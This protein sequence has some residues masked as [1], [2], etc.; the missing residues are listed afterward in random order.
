[1]VAPKIKLWIEFIILTLIVGC[2]PTFATPTPIPPLDSNAIN[3]FIAQTADAASAQTVT[4]MPPSTSTATFTPTPRNT[5]TPEP[6]TTP[7]QTFVFPTVTPVNRYQYFRVKHDHQLAMFN[8]KSR[9][10]DGN[11][12]G[13]LR[14]TPEVVP[15]FLLPKEG[16]GTGRTSL[17]G[18]WEVL[19]NSL[20]NNDQNKLRYLKSAGTA[21]FNTAGFP[22]LESLTMGG[23]I[24]RLD[25]IQGEWGQVHTMDPS[26]PPNAAEVNYATSPDLI[27]K[28]VVV[29]WRRSNK[30]TI[31]VKPPKG[32]LYWPLVSRRP[33]WIQ[34]DRLESFP[35]LPLEV[36]ISKE[37]YL[38]TTPG[39]DLDK[40]G[41]KL[42][43]GQSAK[44][45][46][47]QPAGPD[48]WGSLQN[49][50]WIPLLYGGQ[51]FTSWKMETVPPP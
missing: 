2:M 51:Y 25:K 19:I 34:M 45:V 39:P 36:T 20:N 30:T 33:V 40:T 37:L 27:H 16:S 9:T 24:I 15:L 10:W 49:G 4:A 28:F 13:L 42:S 29:G 17:T 50:R 26:S 22:Q 41:R 47:Y 21:L 46:A 43:A 5:F 48:V 35:I 23:N 3:I 18:G 7:I 32:D 14:Q 12:D 31:L 1:M 44:V 8:Y 11:S 38:Q 6:T